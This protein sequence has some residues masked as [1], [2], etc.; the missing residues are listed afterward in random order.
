MVGISSFGSHFDSFAPVFV[1]VVMVST[2][3]TCVIRLALRLHR[4]LI[5][6]FLLR[7]PWDLHARILAPPST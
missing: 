1:M 7:L 4:R 3:R 2:A 5:F 6:S